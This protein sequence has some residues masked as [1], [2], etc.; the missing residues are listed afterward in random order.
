MWK[1]FLNEKKLDFHDGF[2][3]GMELIGVQSICYNSTVVV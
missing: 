1:L 3:E 2:Q